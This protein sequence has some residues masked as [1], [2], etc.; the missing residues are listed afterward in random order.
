MG[1]WEERGT[2]SL[3]PQLPPGSQVG[4]G[5]FPQQKPQPL[6]VTFFLHLQPQLFLAIDNYSTLLLG[7]Q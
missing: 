7:Q 1:N 6:L 5:Y 3:F 4:S 2:G